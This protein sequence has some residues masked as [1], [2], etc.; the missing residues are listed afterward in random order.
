MLAETQ[1]FFTP[2]WFIRYRREESFMP[3]PTPTP[4]WYA[5]INISPLPFGGE[6]LQLANFT[7]APD[8]TLNTEIHTDPT[9]RCVTKE[10]SKVIN[11]DW[12]NYHACSL[13]YYIYVVPNLYISKNDFT[14]LSAKVISSIYFFWI[15]ILSHIKFKLTILPF[16]ETKL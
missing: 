8:A 11:R 6:L 2:Y 14:K 5:P 10:G 13:S 12:V 1:L 7:L 15:Y 16:A 4:T 9:R 3:T